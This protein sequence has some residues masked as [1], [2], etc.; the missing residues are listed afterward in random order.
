MRTSILKIDLF[1]LV[2]FLIIASGCMTSQNQDIIVEHPIA[3]QS[4]DSGYDSN[5]LNYLG[6]NEMSNGDYNDALDY[7]DQALNLNNSDPV[8]L[9][10]IGFTY[11]LI[12][13]YNE[14]VNYFERAIKYDPS[15]VIYYYN[16]AGVFRRMGDY[17]REQEYLNKALVIDPRSDLYVN[18]RDD[19]TIN[20]ANIRLSAQI[21]V[22]PKNPGAFIELAKVSIN[23][24][25]FENAKYYFHQADIAYEETDI[26]ED[27]E[28]TYLNNYAVILAFNGNDAQALIEFD[29][30]IAS[31]PNNQ[32][33]QKN[34]QIIV[35]EQAGQL[36]RES[37]LHFNFDSDIY[38]IAT[39]VNWSTIS[40]SRNVI[41]PQI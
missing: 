4:K 20:K 33:I 36:S 10:N 17:K 30:A 40:F 5:Y 29:K 16:I 39:N 8:I 11:Y 34:R 38:E 26:K 35:N 22:D 3:N 18:F 9:N 15:D 31:D 24:Y 25:N 28:S 23:E 13:N 6:F 2:A 41:N 27:W 1:L 32:I 21:P 12:G 14:S 19:P 7:F 37:R